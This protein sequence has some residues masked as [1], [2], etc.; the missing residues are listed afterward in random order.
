MRMTNP[1]QP[2]DRGDGSADV[3]YS[4]N[5]SSS[6]G[7][8]TYLRSEVEQLRREMEEMRAK[9]QNGFEPPPQYT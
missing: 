4:T 1:T 6:D 9:I 3:R 7:Q 8:G 2:E 5:G